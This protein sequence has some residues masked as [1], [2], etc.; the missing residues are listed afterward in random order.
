VGG[1]LDSVQTKAYFEKGYNGLF[2]LF[3]IL[4]IG[5]MTGMG[6]ASLLAF[7]FLDNGM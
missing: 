2:R 5:S 1:T 3:T 6:I 7:I 4:I